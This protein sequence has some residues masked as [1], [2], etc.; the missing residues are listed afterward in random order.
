MKRLHLLSACFDF[1]HDSA[2]SFGG[3][4]RSG[5]RWRFG[6]GAADGRLSKHVFAEATEELF[7]CQPSR[8]CLTTETSDEFMNGRLP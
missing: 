2:L 3:V 4:R 6:T 7:R 8:V 5:S 1:R